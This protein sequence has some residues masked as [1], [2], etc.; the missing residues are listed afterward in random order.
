MFLSDVE[1][2]VCHALE[3]TCTSLCIHMRTRVYGS[4]Q[5]SRRLGYKPKHEGSVQCSTYKNTDVEREIDVGGV[6][7]LKLCARKQ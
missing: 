3:L 5:T 2:L 4:A 7:Q 1:E 6:C